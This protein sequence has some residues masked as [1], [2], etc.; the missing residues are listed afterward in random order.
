[1]ARLRLSLEGLS[2]EMGLP[3]FSGTLSESYYILRDLDLS[4]AASS[5]PSIRWSVDGLENGTQLSTFV[6]G[7]PN[8]QATG[9]HLHR[10]CMTFVEGLEFAESGEGLPPGFDDSS[11]K[12]VK[13]LS[14]KLA[15]KGVTG[16]TATFL[17][18]RR[19]A[20]VT[21]LSGKRVAALMAPTYKAIGSVIGRLETISLHR[22]PRF[23]VYDEVSRRP[24]QSTFK[25][26]HLE[27][28]KEALGHRVLV[29]GI[30][31][32]N[33]KGQPLKV[34]ESNFRILPANEQL[35]DTD[36]LIGIA[37]DFTGSLSTGEHLR[38]LMDG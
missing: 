6:T 37:P 14:N 7:K 29:S 13:R 19:S 5:A 27:G 20:R 9:D 2:K 12:H 24:V 21:Q 16:F 31:H 10:V 35:P 28:V 3:V 1:M 18:T 34:E 36:R 30:I 38:K 8:E 25:T 4:I 32:R 15:T 26:E 33:A 11:L 23:L 22:R 17:D